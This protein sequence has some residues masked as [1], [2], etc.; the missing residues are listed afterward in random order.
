M[1]LCSRNSHCSRPASFPVGWSVR[2]AFNS[3]SVLSTYL[4][5][6]DVVISTYLL[7]SESLVNETVRVLVLYVST[8]GVS[9]PEVWSYY[10]FRSVLMRRS[11]K[12]I[13]H[14]IAHDDVLAVNSR[15]L[16]S[17]VGDSMGWNG[18]LLPTNLDKPY[19]I[20]TSCWTPTEYWNNCNLKRHGHVGIYPWYDA[21]LKET[22]C[23]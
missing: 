13:L 9:G 21:S 23:K 14:A 11:G 19:L 10:T 5:L 6:C 8:W 4:P 1:S 12:V 15:R 16:L 18:S 22:S 7:A 20:F 2:G 17:V 3:V